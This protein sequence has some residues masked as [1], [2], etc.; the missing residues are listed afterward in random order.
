MALSW[1]S[2]GTVSQIAVLLQ[3]S[4]GKAAVSISMRELGYAAFAYDVNF[5]KVVQDITSRAGFAF[6]LSLTLRLRPGA[7]LWSAR[8]KHV[9]NCQSQNGFA[10][11]L[12]KRA[13]RGSTAAA[14]S[15]A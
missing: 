13:S 4:S 1:T 12:A 9:V 5:D 6:A 7:L 3:P 15:Q 10:Q 2:N 8:C 14:N 11:S